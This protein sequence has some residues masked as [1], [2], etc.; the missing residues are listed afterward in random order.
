MVNHSFWCNF[1]CICDSQQNEDYVRSVIAKLVVFAIRIPKIHSTRITSREIMFANDFTKTLSPPLEI[2]ER[3]SYIFVSASLLNKDIV[4]IF[5]I[6]LK[7]LITLYEPN[8]HR[9]R[10]SG[11]DRHTNS[12]LE[13]Q[14]FLVG[15]AD[16]PS[17]SKYSISGIID[18]H[19]PIEIS[20]F[21]LYKKIQADLCRLNEKNSM[22]TEV[23]AI[24]EINNNLKVLISNLNN[25]LKKI[26]TLYYHLSPKRYEKLKELTLLGR[27]STGESPG[28]EFFDVINQ[29]K[30]LLIFLS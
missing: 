16:V 24:D 23:L 13:N 30:K 20:A 5:D 1:W 8:Y 27:Y 11:S 14:V 25:D 19:T 10:D 22:L 12:Y 21:N 26:K 9:N 7:N 4:D 28:G 3:P 6:F 29:G 18:L 15:D 17:L 2:R